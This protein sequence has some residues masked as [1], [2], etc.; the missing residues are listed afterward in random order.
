MEGRAPF[1]IYDPGGG[2]AASW[3]SLEQNKVS[4][5]QLLEE[6]GVLKERMKGLKSLG[7]LLEESQ[8]E[9]SRLRQKVEELVRDSEDLRSCPDPSLAK[10]P[11]SHTPTG[12]PASPGPHTPTR[13]PASALLS[14]HPDQRQVPAQAESL[15]DGTHTPGKNEQKPPSSETSSEFEIVNVEEKT[16]R[17][18][19]EKELAGEDGDVSGHLHRLGSALSVFAEETNS[20]Q[21][22]AHLSRMAVDFSRLAAK[23]Q[24]NECKTSV[25][26]TLCEQLRSENE[27]LRR[28]LEND[29]QHQSRLVERIQLEN[30]QL[31]RASGDGGLTGQG[32]TVV[33]SGGADGQQNQ[34]DAEQVGGKKVLEILERKT[35]ALEQQRKELLEVNKQWDQQFRS[36]KQQYEQKIVELRQRLA[37]S[38]RSLSGQVS[39]RDVRQRDFERQLLLAKTRIESGEAEVKELKQKNKCVQDQLMSLTKQREYQER[40]IQWLNKA[41]EEVLTAPAPVF[42]TGETGVGVRR[43]E[44]LTQLEVLK[45]QVKIFQEDFQRERSDRERMNEEKEMLK[46]QVEQ[47]KSQNALLN[48]QDPAERRSSEPSAR[49]PAPFCPSYPVAPYPPPPPHLHGGY[50]WQIHYPP[51]PLGPGH[52]PYRLLDPPWHPLCPTAPR[53]QAITQPEGARPDRTEAPAHGLGKPQH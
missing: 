40:E 50:D 22:L 39:D 51:S 45:H 15:A 6:N 53:I 34:E 36:M 38:Q 10:T 48:T 33:L 3:I 24:H 31:R 27:D 9:A 26:Q 43:Q 23:V 25:L 18:E 21:L 20:N 32:G 28:K 46:L 7:N 2:E 19:G 13:P 49:A 5:Q 52:N 12:P 37:V 4:Y 30:E 42:V 8:T 47:L 41:L 35:R 11:S 14:D 1:R 17:N 29:I 16:Q 44:L